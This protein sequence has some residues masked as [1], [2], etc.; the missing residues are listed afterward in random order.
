M[1]EARLRELLI[2]SL[3]H[4]E[5]GVQV[6]EAALDCVIHEDLRGEWQEYLDQTL[7]HVRLLTDVCRKMG[8]AVDRS[9]PGCQVVQHLG[10]SL[11]RAIDM[12]RA[13]KAPGA[14]QLVAC[15]CVVLAETKDHA[16]WELLTK[17]SEELASD[18]GEA[19]R[20][21]VEEIEDEED[22]HLYH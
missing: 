17:C 14:A 4:E 3:V 10:S 16:K 1:E 19:L 5:G 8:V 2:Q 13:A 7:E 21:A 18:R 20:A 11:V 12:A 15:E 9:T 22:E 6:Y